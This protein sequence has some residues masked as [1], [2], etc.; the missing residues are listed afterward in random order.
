MYVLTDDQLAADRLR[1]SIARTALSWGVPHPPAATRVVNSRNMQI[2]ARDMDILRL[3]GR[4]QQL[5]TPQ[6]RTLVFPHQASRT[7]CDHALKR[8]VA[9]NLLDLVDQRHPGGPKGGSSYNTYQLGS[10]GWPLFM[11]GRRRVARVIRAHQLAIADAYISLVQASRDK[12]LRIENYATEPDSHLEL[13]GAILKPDLYVDLI[14]RQ[15]DDTG[16]KI[17]AWIEVDLGTERQKQVLE[18]VTAYKVAYGAKEQYPLSPYPRV[19][20]LAI[21]DERAAEIRYWLKRAGEMPMR[22]DV[23][24]TDELLTILQR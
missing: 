9:N 17:A 2:L 10:Q 18:Q 23:G 6:I 14:V 13:G 11:T 24:T 12:K 15:A 3:V 8:L 19:I 4:F 7:P 1:R 16:R 22:V 21:N 5:T 20:F